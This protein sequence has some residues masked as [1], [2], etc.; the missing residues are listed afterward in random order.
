MSFW[1]DTKIADNFTTDEKLLYLYLLTNPHTNLCGCY[2]ISINQMSAEIGF[3]KETIKRMLERL[4]NEHQSVI[5][6]EETKEV[7]LLN[8]H[9]YNWTSSEKFRK[10]LMKEISM[11]KEKTFRTYLQKISE[12]EDTVSIPYPYGS[13]T[14]VSVTDTVTV[15]DTVSDTVSDSKPIKHKYG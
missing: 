10:P 2:E 13:D 4:Q 1:T 8:W 3:K 14:T 6:S 12:G 9:K 15:T 11:V 5:Y 7:L